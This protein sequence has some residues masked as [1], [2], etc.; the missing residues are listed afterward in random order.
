MRNKNVTVIC[1]VV[2]L[3]AAVLFN[4]CSKQVTSATVVGRYVAN[5]KQA[6]DV[7]DVRPDGTYILNYSPSLGNGVTN[8]GTWTFE[9]R[10]G[11]PRLAFS[12][13]FFGLPK[14]GAG[15]SATWDVEVEQ[16]LGKTKL[17]IDPDLRYFYEKQ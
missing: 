11:E 6:V 3:F 10:N 8:T 2:F 17:C 1:F 7:L 5:H 16:S 9:Y 13:F 15:G 14:Y 12:K 4:G